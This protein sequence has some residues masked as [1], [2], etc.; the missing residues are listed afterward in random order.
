M[1]GKI[2]NKKPDENAAPAYYKEAA[3]ANAK[4]VYDTDKK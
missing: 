4:P 2:E 1:G 3:P